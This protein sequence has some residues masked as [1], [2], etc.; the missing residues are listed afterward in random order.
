M[1]YYTKK[2][3]KIAKFL[4]KVQICLSALFDLPGIDLWNSSISARELTFAGARYGHK[5][6]RKSIKHKCLYV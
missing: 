1:R 3:L 2:I 5:K 4:T 6:F